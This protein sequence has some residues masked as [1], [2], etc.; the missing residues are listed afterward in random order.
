M[1]WDLGLETAF[2]GITDIPKFA[3]TFFMFH[4]NIRKSGSAPRTPI[5]HTEASINQAFLK[6]PNKGFSNGTRTN[7]IHGKAGSR[8]VT[9]GSQTFELHQNCIARFS[10]PLP[11]P[12]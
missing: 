9:T 6:E 11:H 2:K 7:F 3:S 12:F 10:P 5:H 4:F 8:P 1:M